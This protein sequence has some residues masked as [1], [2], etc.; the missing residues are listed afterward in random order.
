MKAYLGFIYALLAALFNG[1]IGVVSVKIMASGL[2]PFE[3]AFYKCL[4]SFI[5]ILICLIISKQWLGWITHL[6]MHYKKISICA[7]FGFFI[8]YFFETNSYYY[9]KVPVAIFLLLG[10]ST[11]TAFTLSAILNK[12][13]ITCLEI[14]SILLAISGLAL[15]FGLG[16]EEIIKVSY[17]GL[18]LAFIAGIGYGAFLT[19]SSFFKIGSGLIVVNSLLLFGTSYLF[20]PCLYT[21]LHLPSLNNF[22][23][24]LITAIVPTIG[25]FWFTTKALTL[26]KSNSV[27][28]IELSEPIFATLM[29]F[30]F[31]NQ[32]LNML[33]MIGGALIISAIY[34]NYFACKSN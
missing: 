8:L 33:Q 14:L 29:A 24:L 16:S 4:I 9:E 22:Y 6:R 17:K 10:S 32:Q 25:G 21:G 19:L 34:V 2:H 1:V 3:V 26:L 18:A 11:L 5:I 31:L 7:F 23:L 28:L 20:I 15:L 30:F 12:R 27:Q 13:C